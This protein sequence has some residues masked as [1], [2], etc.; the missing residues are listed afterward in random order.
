MTE[1]ALPCIRHLY[2]VSACTQ[3]ELGNIWRNVNQF[4]DQYNSL[5]KNLEHTFTKVNYAL[6]GL[7]NQ[8]QPVTE[9]VRFNASNIRILVQSNEEC[10]ASLAALQAHVNNSLINADKRFLDKL[11]KQFSDLSTVVANAREELLQQ[12][13][14]LNLC[15]QSVESD[16]HHFSEV[17]GQFNR[18]Q[19]DGYNSTASSSGVSSDCEIVQANSMKIFLY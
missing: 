9:Q 5:V 8:W 3:L 11:K 6:Q 13:A 2:N 7:Q 17:L 16:V 15:L 14:S 4:S 19:R 1:Y 18:A 10:Q 12:V